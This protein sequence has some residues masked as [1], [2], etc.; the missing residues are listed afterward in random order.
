MGHTAFYN[1]DGDMLIVAQEGTLCITT[2]FGR[3]TV[4]PLEICV[5]QRGIKFKVDLEGEGCKARGF[6]CE[7]YKSHFVLPDLGPIGANSLANP[8]HF[9]TP[10]AWYEDTNDEWRII[11]KF[12]GEFFE[13]QINHSP[14]DIVAW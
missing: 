8:I 11:S 9:K 13:Y 7:T 4:S 3:M 2:E 1:S 14:F 10:E 5:I 12:S 6:I